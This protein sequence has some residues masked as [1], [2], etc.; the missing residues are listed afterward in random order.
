MRLREA[1][2]RDLA[3]MARLE[4]SCFPHDA[5]SGATFWAELA[6]RP[7]RSYW[8]AVDDVQDGDDV[9]D[10]DHVQDGDHAQGRDEVVGYAGLDVAGDLADVMTVAVDPRRRGAGLGARL[11]EALHAR[12]RDAG[13]GA[14]LLEVRADNEA[15]LSLYAAHGYRVVR[16]RRG[17]YRST[18]GAP[19]VDALVMRKE[20]VRP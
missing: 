16:T 5:W 9:R 4:E 1:T 10:G 15:A 2:W 20:L 7:R 17:Y 6:Q 8:V 19:P 11:L 12:A 14:V 3:A 13:A 18:G